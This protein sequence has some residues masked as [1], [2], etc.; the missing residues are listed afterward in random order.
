RQRPFTPLPLPVLWSVL[1]LSIATS[2]QPCPRASRR[3]TLLARVGQRPVPPVVFA[4]TAGLLMQARLDAARIPVSLG[5]F[6]RERVPCLLAPAHFRVALVA[7]AAGARLASIEAAGVEEEGT[8]HLAVRALSFADR[9]RGGG[10]QG[11]HP[12]VDSQHPRDGAPGGQGLSRRHSERQVED[13]YAR[14]TR[15]DHRTQRRSHQLGPR[16][17]PY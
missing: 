1:R 7:L 6:L 4:P 5:M 10:D 13:G 12:P 17:Q 11:V 9:H 2:A 16:L 3:M 8:A 14:A 15:R